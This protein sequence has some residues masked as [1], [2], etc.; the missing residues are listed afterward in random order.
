[1]GATSMARGGVIKRFLPGFRREVGFDQQHETSYGDVEFEFL[2]DIGEMSSLANS[3]SS[4]EYQPNEIMEFEEDDGERFDSNDVDNR[5][6]WDN[7]HQLLQASICR[8]SSLESRIRNATKEAIQEIKSTETAC[9]CSRQMA[10]AT[11][12]RSCFMR[13]VSMRLQNAGFDNAICKTKW[14]SSPNIPSGEHTFLDLIDTTSS[15]RGD[16]IR[17]IIELN[18]RA[19]FEM[20]KASEDYNRLVRRLPELFVGKVER[21]SNLIKI[22]CMAAKRCMKENKMHM[23]PWRKYRY[24]QA[25]WLGPCE[26]TTS[27]TKVSMRYSERMPKPKAKASMLTVDLLEKLPNVHYTAVEVV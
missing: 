19:E 18:F 16:V 14:K 3:A 20:A 8:T 24:M 1:M 21:L 23:G 2:D 4:D 12:C 15:K 13:E 22:L 5:S 9:S 7:Q 27:T 25:K 17:V 11:S 6:F 10:S 26:R